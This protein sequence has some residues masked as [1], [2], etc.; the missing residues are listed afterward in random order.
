MSLRRIVP[1]LLP[2]YRTMTARSTPPTIPPIDRGATSFPKNIHDRQS[3]YDLC[4]MLRWPAHTII[5]TCSCVNA[6][7]ASSYTLPHNRAPAPTR[8]SGAIKTGHPEHLRRL[9][10]TQYSLLPSV[11]PVYLTL[12]VTD[13]RQAVYCPINTARLTTPSRSYRMD[14]DKTRN[15]SRR[16]NTATLQRWTVAPC[17]LYNWVPWDTHRSELPRLSLQWDRSNNSSYQGICGLC[18]TL[19]LKYCKTSSVA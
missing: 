3:V 15:S 8:R 7:A 10:A 17:P 9:F 16:N 1:A 6:A 5:S 18:I 4:S 11:L 12:V 19:E 14:S 2:S 13:C